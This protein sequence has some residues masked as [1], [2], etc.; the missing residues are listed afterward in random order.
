MRVSPARLDEFGSFL[1]ADDAEGVGGAGD[2]GDIPIDTIIAH[3]LPGVW[4]ALVGLPSFILFEEHLFIFEEE[5]LNQRTWNSVCHVPTDLGNAFLW[6]G[7]HKLEITSVSYHF[8]L[9]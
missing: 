2:A 9:A 4:D 1:P 8:I 7:A 6:S 3:P 5:A